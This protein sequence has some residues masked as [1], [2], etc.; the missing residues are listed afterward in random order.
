[1]KSMIIDNDYHLVLSWLSF[2]DS[3]D[4]RSIFDK[5]SVQYVLNTIARHFAIIV[6]LQNLAHLLE[7]QSFQC[8]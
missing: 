7:F 4:N 1:M 3:V 8:H 6:E 2:R 5:N